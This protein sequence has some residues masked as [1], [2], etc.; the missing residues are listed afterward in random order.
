VGFQRALSGGR[1]SPR[2]L[3]G[4]HAL[5]LLRAAWPHAVGPGLARRSEVVA[6]EHG[7]LWVRVPDAGWRRVLHRMRR[8]LHGRLRAVAGDLAPARIAF[9]EGPVTAPSPEPEPPHV[10]GPPPAPPEAV[11]ASARAIADPELRR[12]FLEASARY[13]Q[14]FPSEDR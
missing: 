1:T 5:V 13:L 12:A 6:L 10:P 11:V 9:L 7:A 14:R 3:F 4:R 8:T 2:R